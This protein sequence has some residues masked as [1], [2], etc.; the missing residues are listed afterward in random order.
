MSRGTVAENGGREA[1][2][3]LVGAIFWVVIL[4]M[5]VALIVKAGPLYYDNYSLQNILED[6]ARHSTPG[7]SPQ[8]IMSDLRDRLRVAMIHIRQRDISIV[9]K[10]AGPVE[11]RADYVRMVPLAGNVSLRIHFVARSG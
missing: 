6:Q 7:E 8:Q 11:I 5:A 4:A 2:I 1:G 9:Q 10:G 3:G